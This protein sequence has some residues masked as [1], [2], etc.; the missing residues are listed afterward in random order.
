MTHARLELETIGLQVVRAAIAPPPLH[1]CTSKHGISKLKYATL[2]V[3]SH[4]LMPLKNFLKLSEQLLE[5]KL[6]R[7]FRGQIP[8]LCVLA[9]HST[10]TKKEWQETAN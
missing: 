8:R 3:F 7:L 1:T 6:L 10:H 4:L 9:K 2:T 5:V